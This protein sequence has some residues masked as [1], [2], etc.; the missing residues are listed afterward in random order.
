MNFLVEQ[1]VECPHCGE[2]YPATIDTSQGS[3]TTI[4]DCA[5]C[6]APIHLAVECEAGEILSIGI[7]SAD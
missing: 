7:T 5:V 6:C 2:S 4:E 1:M 3:H